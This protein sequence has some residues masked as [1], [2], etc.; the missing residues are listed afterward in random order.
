MLAHRWIFLKCS[1]CCRFRK[2]EYPPYR[3]HPYLTH[4]SDANSRL[5]LALSSADISVNFRPTVI[6]A[7]KTWYRF[8]ILVDVSCSFQIPTAL[9]REVLFCCHLITFYL[10]SLYK[11]RRASAIQP[12][13]TANWLLF[14]GF[15]K[16]FY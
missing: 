11:L 10:F 9:F 4:I 14:I 12:I 13:S 1:F 2:S 6:P 3:S 15:F 7:H 5:L 16:Y 8:G